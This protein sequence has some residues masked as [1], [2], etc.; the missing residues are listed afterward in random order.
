MS[1]RALEV[2]SK[3]VSDEGVSLRVTA[4]RVAK[5]ITLVDVASSGGV[6][7]TMSLRKAQTLEQTA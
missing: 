5:G 7:V 3:L 6:I 2:G 1:K 4:I